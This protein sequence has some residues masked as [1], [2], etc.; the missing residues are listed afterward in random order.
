MGGDGVTT[1]EWLERLTAL[2][3]A[4]GHE[5]VVFGELRRLLAPTFDRSETD[6][7]GNLLLWRDGPPGSPLLLFTAHADQVAL[8]V[9]EHLPGGFL[10]FAAPAIDP[11]CLPALGVEVHGR[12][13]V[14]GMLPP[15]LRQP[16][17]EVKE[18]E[19]DLYIDFGP[20]AATDLPMVGEP[21]Y[22]ATEPRLLGEDR[23]CAAGLDDRAS[24]AAIA[25]ALEELQGEDLPLTVLAAFTAQEETGRGGAAYLCRQVQPDAAVVLDVTFGQ[26]P[27]VDQADLPLLGRG[28]AVGIGPNV[29]PGLHRWLE[30]VAAAGDIPCQRE[31]LPGDSGTDGWRLQLAGLGVPTALLSI[32]LTSMHSPQEV[33]SV[34]DVSACG[35]L[36]ADLARSPLP[37]SGTGKGA[38]PWS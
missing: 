10:R 11:A 31:P 32:P 5:E 14:V 20:E 15:H 2:R 37:S 26:Q 1:V 18:G 13:G 35:H 23:F 6:A 22:F 27:E 7:A 30:A 33:V 38:T 24:V 34:R 16:G 3:A 4:S 29:P 21:V 25:L 19:R 17:A 12:Q 36:L 9:R 28:G 8:W